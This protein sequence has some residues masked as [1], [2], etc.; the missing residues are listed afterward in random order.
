MIKA[1][2]N[3]ALN[4]TDA[5]QAA[6]II[7]SDVDVANHTD[8]FD[9]IASVDELKSEDVDFVDGDYADIDLA[10]ADQT[11]Y[12]VSQNGIDCLRIAPVDDSIFKT[13]KEA[14]ANA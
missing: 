11:Y 9:D 13:I 8:L 5:Q 2:L 7:K 4:A 12:Y 1:T 6:S 10:N 14:L 3:Q